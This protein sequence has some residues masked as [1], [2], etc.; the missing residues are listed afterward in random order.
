MVLQ[1]QDS[2]TAPGTSSDKGQCGPVGRNGAAAFTGAK[3]VAVAHGTLQSGDP[4]PGCCE[5]RVYRQKEP[6]T[7]VRILGRPPLE[8]TVFE[9]ERLRCNACGEVFTTDEPQ[10]AGPQKYDPTAV[11]MIALFKYGTG[12]PFHRMERL[13]RQLG[14]H[15]ARVHAVGLVE[16]AA[17]WFWPVLDE[18]IQQ[19]AQ[20]SLVHNDDTG[21]RV[22]K[23][24]RDTD[25]GRTGTFT[26]GIVSIR[27][28][29]KIALY[30]TGWKH[31][32]ENLADVLN[33]GRRNRRLPFRCATRYPGTRQS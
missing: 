27:Q 24:V 11:A 7:L 20:G 3:R 9:M 21:M 28:E 12:M 23:L 2:E 33:S 8:A 30:F 1:S 18:V 29:W 17:G 4:C 26:T 32:G 19:A 6:K 5:G 16:Q 14:I 10:A 15:I 22:L 25:D 31:A 13:E